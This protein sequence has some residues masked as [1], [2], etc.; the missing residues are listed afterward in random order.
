MKT[1]I[2]LIVSAGLFALSFSTRLTGDQNEPNTKAA[3]GEK[4]F[5]DRPGGPAHPVVRPH[6]Q[7]CF[8]S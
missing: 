5:F 1:S 4:L 2:G 6:R 8:L 3:L 7:L